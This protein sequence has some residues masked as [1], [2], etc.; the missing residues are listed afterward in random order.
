[1]MSAAGSYYIIWGNKGCLNPG[2]CCSLQRCVSSPQS[3]RSWKRFTPQAVTAGA[4]G[5]RRQLRV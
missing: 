3:F 1:M 5:P 2:L 4:Q